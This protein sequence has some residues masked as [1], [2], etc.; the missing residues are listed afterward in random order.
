[1]L[2]GFE[3]RLPV[4]SGCKGNGLQQGAKIPSMVT[5][6]SKRITAIDDV[7]QAWYH[8]LCVYRLTD[9]IN[10]LTENCNL[11]EASHLSGQIM[12]QEIHINL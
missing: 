1:M 7:N 2:V 9:C 10:K 5:L 8:F 11:I 4:L 12:R 6:R 3:P